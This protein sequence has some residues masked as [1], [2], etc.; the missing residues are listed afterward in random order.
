MFGHIYCIRLSY[1][2]GTSNV[3]QAPF[4]YTY[5]Q[6]VTDLVKHGANINAQTKV[7]HVMASLQNA[8]SCDV[9]MPFTFL[10]RPG[11]IQDGETALTWAAGKKGCLDIV[12]MLVSHG[13]ELNI[14]DNVR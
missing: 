2:A 14:Q 8:N 1:L 4:L 3:M 13:A 10:C 9:C 5:A 7:R 12:E 6:E 11:C